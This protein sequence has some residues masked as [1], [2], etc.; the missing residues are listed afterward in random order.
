LKAA[1]E[2]H[3]NVFESARNYD[4]ASQHIAE[5]LLRV[6]PIEPM[7]TRVDPILATPITLT[8]D[9]LKQLTQFVRDGLLDD[10]AKADNLVRQKP[11]MV[12]SGLK[13]TYFEYPD[14]HDPGGLPCTQCH[15]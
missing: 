5:D 2:H 1:I 9:E 13:V 8:T 7:L 15:K 11:A 3:L 14:R 12:P 4:P 10:R 6:G